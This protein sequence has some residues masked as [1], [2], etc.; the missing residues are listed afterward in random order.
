M[1]PLHSLTISPPSTLSFSPPHLPI[2]PFPHLHPQF[3][4]PSPRRF[5]PTSLQN[6]AFDSTTSQPPR[7][8]FPGGYKRP[9]IR[10]PNIVLQLTPDDVLLNSGPALDF[11]DAALVKSV[12]IVVIGDG[13]GGAKLYEAACLLKSLIRD[14]AYLLVLDRVDIAAAVN[15]TGVLLSDQG[16]PPIVARNTLMGSKSESVY[17]PVIG[18]MVQTVNAAI[19]ACDSEGADFLIFSSPV[20]EHTDILRE[21][22]NQK[23]EIPV[24]YQSSFIKNDGFFNEV[25]MKIMPGASGVVTTLEELMSNGDLLGKL[26]YNIPAVN[27]RSPKEITNFSKMNLLNTTNG[28][29]GNLGFDSSVKLED[30]EAQFIKKERRVLV[31]AANI[32]EKAA[33]L[34]EEIS[35]LNDAISQLDEPFLL[36]IVGEFNSGKSTFINALLGGKFL[37]DGVVP[38]TNEI[39]FLRY[40]E[41][42]TQQQQSFERDPD[43]RYICYLPS[44]ILK[45]MIVVD[46]PG[47]N[48]ILQ[49]Q[50]RLTEEFVPRADLLLFVLS[51]DRPLTE[52]EVAFLRYTQ[53]WKKKVVFLLNKADMYRNSS[54]LDE[55]ITFVRENVQ[56][57]LNVEDVK[58][59]PISARSALDAKLA[60]TVAGTDYRDLLVSQAYSTTQGFIEFENFLN[61]FLDRSTTAGLERMKIKLET[62]IGI[63]ERL[64]FSCQTLVTQDCRYAK[65]DLMSVKELMGTVQDY[66]LRMDSECFSWKRQIS[67]L[68]ENTK[69]RVV[70]LVESTLQLSNL[71]LAFS[72]ISK[73]DKSAL[74]PATQSVHD[75]IVS[76]ALSD[77]HRL[78]VDY[79]AWLKEKYSEEVARYKETLERRWPSVVDSLKQTE[80]TIKYPLKEDD[81]QSIKSIEK[82]SGTT[83][84]RLFDQEIRQV[85]LGAFGGLGAAGL[86]ASLLTSVLPSTLEDLLA[87]GLCSAGGLLAISSFPARKQMVVNK[88]KSIANEAGQEIEEAMQKDLLSTIKSL[89]YSVSEIGKP[90]EE[91]AQQRLDRLLDTQEQLTDIE[92]KLK[93]LQVELQNLHLS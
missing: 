53:Q 63:A 58:L 72:L 17:L 1:V 28:L 69:L 89:E 34:M 55:A 2:L 90:F 93:T 81:W 80:Y 42:G 11:I 47:T 41:V 14:R 51:A 33:P 74:V 26:V 32:I 16:L 46:T 68:V 44:K 49:R 78:L 50:Q 35:L 88:V 43:G 3:H 87:L 73:G 65:K 18:K 83:A 54:E 21:S 77:A 36:V 37:K 19:F 24:F 22:I 91:A 29:G 13:G 27:N 10:V 4:K 31:A 61:G 67:S 62:P 82:F 79:T 60:A 15:A 45:K 86:S 5:T 39:T 52:S 20:E 8:L 85:F 64:L 76:P 84:S 7:T 9:E 25:P 23:I 6:D 40:T 71:D 56:K 38:T 75:D 57:L 59:F 12:G 70:K 30:S 92:K 66:A 48:V